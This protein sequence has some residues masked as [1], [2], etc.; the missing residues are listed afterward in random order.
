MFLIKTRATLF[1]LLIAV[2]LSTWT[3][4][5]LEKIDLVP[6][7]GIIAFGLALVLFN[8]LYIDSLVE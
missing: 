4:L 2:L 5:D 3:L 6:L 1:S 8:S 7:Q